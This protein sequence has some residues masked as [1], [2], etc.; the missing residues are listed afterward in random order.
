MHRQGGFLIMLHR[1]YRRRGYGTEAVRG[2]FD[3][4]FAGIGLHD[5]R[6]SIDRRNAPARRMAEKAAIGRRFYRG[7]IYQ[8]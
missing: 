3:F 6:V 2:L 1:D 7:S 8:G 5:V 4:A